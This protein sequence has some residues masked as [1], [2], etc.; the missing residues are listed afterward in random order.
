MKKHLAL[1]SLLIILS[2]FLLS[3]CSSNKEEKIV[4]ADKQFEKML[5]EELDKKEIYKSDLSEISGIMI[6]A[7][8]VLGLSGGGHKDKSVI[9]FG[10]EEFEYEKV[11][12]KEFGTIKT[13]EDLKNFPKLTSIRIYLQPNIDFN[14]IPNKGNITNLGLSQNKISNLEFLEGFDKLLYLSISSN[15][16]VDLKGIENVPKLKRLNLNS[17]DIESIPQLAS[18]KDLEN[19]DLTYNSVDDVSPLKDLS[20]L[21][22]L[23]LYGNGISD[24][25]PL[26]N[27]K[28]LKQLFLNNNRITDISALKDFASFEDLNISGNPI[29]NYEVIKHIENAVK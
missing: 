4:F 2:I 18:F 15:K 28:S 29:K 25:T 22:Y 19:L 14:T 17:N 9:L 16:I 20:K 7:D 13:L 21:N 6:A 1:I 5:Q 10:F 8:R 27:I 12:Y 24:I 3:G 23:S 26:A 11:R